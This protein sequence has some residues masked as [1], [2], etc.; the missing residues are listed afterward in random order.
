MASSVVAGAGEESA[1][2]GKV[3]TRIYWSGDGDFLTEAFANIP[4]ALK[5]YLL[6]GALCQYSRLLCA[7][8]SSRINMATSIRMW[9]SFAVQYKTRIEPN[10]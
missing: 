2:M 1:V 5:V 3:L 6:D 4:K 8:L 9:A 10:H 7:S